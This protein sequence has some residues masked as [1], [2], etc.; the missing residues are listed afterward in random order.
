MK[1]FF[2][3]TSWDD[4]SIYDLRLA[5]LL[6]KYEMPATFY[7]PINNPERKMMKFREIRAIGDGFEIG[8]H[9][10][11]HKVLTGISLK[12]AKREISEGKKM[13]EDIIG[14]EVTS[15]CYPKGMYNQDIKQLVG[16]LGFA[17][18]RT[19]RLFGTQILDKL[20]AP[21]SVHAYDHKPVVYI[22]ELGFRLRS[23]SL[24]RLGLLG[25]L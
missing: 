24:R 4:G 23:G 18:A 2:V 1:Q 19:V 25:K 14:R 22:R 8:G 21:T 10:E 16:F 11:N 20:Q 6:S 9:T 5:E 15:F 7:I 3:T 12:E 17:Y 13:L